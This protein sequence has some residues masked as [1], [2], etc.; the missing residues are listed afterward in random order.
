MNE[1]HLLNTCRKLLSFDESTGLFNWIV[2]RGTKKA[3]DLAGGLTHDGYW[4]IRI[5]RKHYAAHRLA[6]LMTYGYLPQ[7]ID[8]INNDRADNRV[9][10]LREA[11]KSENCRNRKSHKGSSSKFKGV[12]WH[13]SDKRW[14]ASI[15]IHG[16]LR[17]LGQYMS[18]IDAAKAYDQVAI[19]EFGKFAKTNKDMGLL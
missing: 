2:S 19:K 12:F 6:Y 8:H 11:S 7:F 18:E 4:T 14:R 10:N 13:K 5:N 15:Y 17:Y 9:A 3:G 16:K 1:P